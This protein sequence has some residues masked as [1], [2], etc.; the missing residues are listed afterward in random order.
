VNAYPE[1]PDLASG[2]EKGKQN[3]FLSVGALVSL[4]SES[5]K[6]ILQPQP[7]IASHLVVMFSL[8]KTTHNFVIV[9]VKEQRIFYCICGKNGI[10]NYVL[11]A[12]LAFSSEISHHL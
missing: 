1:A 4:F 12:S 10:G 9:D 5:V 6:S 2:T 11:S 7:R 3:S 8:L